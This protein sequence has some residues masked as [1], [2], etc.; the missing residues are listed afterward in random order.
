MA[1]QE[2][3]MGE[4][5]VKTIYALCDP[6][7][8]EP[9]YVGQTTRSLDLRLSEH[10]RQARSRDWGVH[11]WIRSLDPVKPKIV[12]L[13]CDP[14]DLD[15]AERKWIAELKAGGVKLLNLTVGGNGFGGP[16]PQEVR[17]RIG[18]SAKGRKKSLET[19]RKLSEA[20]RGRKLTQE[21][22]EKMAAAHRGKKLTPEQKD[23]DGTAVHAARTTSGY[24]DVSWDSYHQEWRARVKNIHL[25]YFVYPEEADEAVKAFGADYARVLLYA[26][27]KNA[28]AT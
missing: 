19:R 1:D 25:G 14:P 15:T 6:K 27:P 13:E 16:H 12:E 5:T 28:K 17:E 11:K 24:R 20:L 4:E 21:Q 22:I 8:L 7:T 9:R 23:S 26:Y 10:V 18:A 3:P 2:R